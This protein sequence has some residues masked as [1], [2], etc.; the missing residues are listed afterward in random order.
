MQPNNE[1]FFY[2]DEL[3]AKLNGFEPPL[4]K[5]G[6]ETIQMMRSQR[7]Q[8]PWAYIYW[9]ALFL[10]MIAIP[11]TDTHLPTSKINLNTSLA[12]NS[13]PKVKTLGKDQTFLSA[14]DISDYNP[15]HPVNEVA[16]ADYV[17]PKTSTI[18]S[19][20]SPNKSTNKI[21]GSSNTLSPL[22]LEDY[23][24]I[25]APSATDFDNPSQGKSEMD[26]Q[27][28]IT[29][30]DITPREAHLSNFG[31]PINGL[32]SK[33]LQPKA[34]NSTFWNKW[35]REV[36]FTPRLVT[37]LYHPDNA[38][39]LLVLPANQQQDNWRF[40]TGFQAA[41]RITRDL[42]RAFVL[43]GASMQTTHETVNIRL[44]LPSNPQQGIAPD[45]RTTDVKLDA[46]Y[47]FAGV[48]AG[49]G[50]WLDGGKRWRTT[51]TLTAS[52]LLR[53]TARFIEKDVVVSSLRFP[54]DGGVQ[55]IN[56]VWS[57]SAGYVH[58]LSCSKA[59][60]FIEPGVSWIVYSNTPKNQPS[61]LKPFM[62]DVHLGLRW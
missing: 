26:F 44:D 28:P 55:P 54:A 25:T 42:G 32:E 14:A 31:G 48:Q 56:L 46:N 23:R 1:D 58:P 40:R 9:V 52:R 11:A 45:M 37:G 41:F 7:N 5:G 12:F 59:A 19:L 62:V 13:Q 3:R 60:W 39:N 15:I 61:S 10:S 21:G 2:D 38:T 18:K 27:Q 24:P 20:T 6:F 30:S 8:K 57:A 47:L 22:Y 33:I 35:K 4:P 53:G 16:Q 34:P 17:N 36:V 51:Q 49:G 43:G 50:Y 29:I